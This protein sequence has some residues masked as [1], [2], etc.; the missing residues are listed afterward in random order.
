MF[1]LITPPVA[2]FSNDVFLKDG[3]RIAE[4]YA[5][6]G[7]AGVKKHIEKTGLRLYTH[8]P[9]VGKHLYWWNEDVWGKRP[10]KFGIGRG[11]VIQDK[12]GSK[13]EEKKKGFRKGRRT[14]RKRRSRRR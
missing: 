14:R 9:L 4:K 11:V 10:A 3:Y 1:G 13:A 6:E 5:K 2:S 8:I 7:S 12:Y